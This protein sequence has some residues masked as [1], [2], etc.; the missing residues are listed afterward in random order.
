VRRVCL[1]AFYMD[2]HEVTNAEFAECMKDGGCKWYTYPGGSANF[3]KSEYDDYPVIASVWAEANDYCA[4]AGKRLPTEAEWEY[5]ARGGLSGKRYPRGDTISCPDDNYG[6]CGPS[7]P[8]LGFGG[9]ENR[10]Q[11]VGSYAPNGYGLH[12]MAGNVSEYVNDWY[13]ANYYVG[14]PE[15]DIDPPGPVEW[16]APCEFW[17][18]SIRVIRGGSWA[19]ISPLLLRVSYRDVESGLTNRE[20]GFR[21]AMDP[22]ASVVQW[23]RSRSGTNASLVGNIDNEDRSDNGMQEISCYLNS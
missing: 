7:A 4:W 13:S 19:S 5:A 11:K 9:H 10:T 15:P 2:V 1:P 21:C 8:C 22:S 3:G 14:R 23:T 16:E 6:R 20:V 17:L 18:P 12:D